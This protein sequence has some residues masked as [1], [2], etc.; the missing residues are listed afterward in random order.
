M[1]SHNFSS[2][3]Q[4]STSST[5]STKRKTYTLRKIYKPKSPK[6]TIS[7]KHLKTQNTPEKSEV[8]KSKKET[9]KSLTSKR[10]RNPSPPST[11][12]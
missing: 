4:K 3:S 10:K 6:I 11:T 8:D 5:K 7:L 9:E 1:N 2:Q 12:N